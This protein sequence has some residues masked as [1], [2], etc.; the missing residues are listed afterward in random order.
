MSAV[1]DFMKANLHRSVTRAE[2][3]AVVNLSPSYVSYL[4][5]AEVGVSPGE[6]LIRLKMEKAGELLRTTFLSIKQVMA[7]VGYNNKSNFGRSFKLRFHVSPSEYRQHA[8][9]AEPPK[10]E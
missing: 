1:I 9:T 5:K 2:L 3:A 8:L 6:Y 4:F 10:D 7:E